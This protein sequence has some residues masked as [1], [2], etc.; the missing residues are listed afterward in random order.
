MAMTVITQM[1]KPT[2]DD[3]IT[4]QRREHAARIDATDT[5]KTEIITTE[6]GPKNARVAVT[7]KYPIG[8]QYIFAVFSENPAFHERPEDEWRM[9]ARKALEKFAGLRNEQLVR[10]P[11]PEDAQ[12]MNLMCEIR[13]NLR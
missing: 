7:L 8:G 9:A 13:G 5:Y 1:D 2:E 12:P 4:R 10:G 11:R 3:I 6:I